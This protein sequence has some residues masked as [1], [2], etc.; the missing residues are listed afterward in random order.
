MAF[1]VADYDGMLRAW[2]R[3]GRGDCDMAGLHP[4]KGCRGQTFSCP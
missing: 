3:A 2:G 4:S 1:D